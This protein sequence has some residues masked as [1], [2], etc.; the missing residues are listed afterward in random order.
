M[1]EISVEDLVALGALDQPTGV[2]DV[3]GEDPLL[4]EV[5]EGCPPIFQHHGGLDGTLAWHILDVLVV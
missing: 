3:D 2:G 5:K 4:E 1:I